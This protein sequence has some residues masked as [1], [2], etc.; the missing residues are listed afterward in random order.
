M[1][2]FRNH[3]EIAEIGDAIFVAVLQPTLVHLTA[4]GAE[5]CAVKGLAIGHALEGKRVGDPV[6]VRTDVEFAFLAA[7]CLRRISTALIVH[8]NGNRTAEQR[9]IRPLDALQFHQWRSRLSWSKCE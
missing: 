8:G 7:H 2:F 9:I 4:I 1:N 3:S 6:R 5:C